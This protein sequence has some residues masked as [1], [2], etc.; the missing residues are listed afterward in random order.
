MKTVKNNTMTILVLGLLLTFLSG[1]GAKQAAQDSELQIIPAKKPV[2]EYVRDDITY[3]VDAYDPWEGFN[4]HMYVFNSHFDKYFFLP[5]VKAYEWITPDYVEDRISGI[6]KNFSEIQ[7]FVNNL[8]QLKG[9]ETCVCAG[10]FLVNT[11]IGLAGMY[12]PATKMDLTAKPEDFGQTLGHYGVGPGPYLVL[13]VFGP[14][15]L[16]DAGG[17]AVDTAG[18]SAV[19]YCILDDVENKS[20]IHT[21]IDVLNAV[22]TRHRT[23]FR[24]YQ[25]GS[26]FEYE[27]LRMLYLEKRK[28]DI[29]K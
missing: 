6:F 20:N 1:C 4:R 18:R 22:D 2:S 28:M 10:R 29:A 14:S 17:L 21:A 27:L 15:T 25:S 11:T 5:V 19:L 23:P 3:S 13:P 9:R 7:N 24:Y 26:P 16:R 12:D 8:F